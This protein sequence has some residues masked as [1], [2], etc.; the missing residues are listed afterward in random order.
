MHRFTPAAAPERMSEGIYLLVG[1]AVG[2]AVFFVI[3]WLLGSRQRAKT[4]EE[5]R[6][7]VE[8]RQLLTQRESELSQARDQ[9][10]E[11]NN[12]RRGGGIGS[13]GTTGLS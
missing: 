1:F 6:L 3:G 4:P 5:D 7:E 10:T 12:A 8:L 13:G 9:L 2:G 11:A